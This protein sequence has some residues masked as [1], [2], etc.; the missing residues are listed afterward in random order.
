M[1]LNVFASAII[2]WGFG[3][4]LKAFRLPALILALLFPIMIVQLGMSGIRQ[5]IAVALLMGSASSFLDGRRIQTAFWILAAAAFH[6]SAAIFLPI[7][8]IAGRQ[9]KLI[10]LVAA[11]AILLPVAII[12]GGDR[13]E[14]Y[15][16]RYVDQIYGDVSSGGAVIR[17]AMIL[18]P[19][20]IFFAYSKKF[21]S[22]CPREFELFK[23]FAIIIVVTGVSGFVS[24]LALHRLNYYV[25]PFSLV[26]FAYVSI[27]LG[28]RNL[29]SQFA[30][31]LAPVVMYGAYMVFW[32]LTS[33]HADM[34]Y[35][36]YES[37]SFVQDYSSEY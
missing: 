23:L 22:A 2:L 18:L 31:R 4:F 25:M 19:T 28:G 29:Q 9:V 13:F 3:N 17:Y 26:I 32:L 36:P 11:V 12:L 16:D 35:I 21:R 1:W 7:A 6:S 37:F 33:R 15:Q 5:G 34:C 10:R 30:L 24:S 8:F 14:T 20:L 27:V